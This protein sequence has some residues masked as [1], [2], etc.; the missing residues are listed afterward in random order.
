MK[1][2]QN[3]C[4]WRPTVS[5][6]RLGDAKGSDKSAAQYRKRRSHHRERYET[7]SWRE[8]LHVAPRPGFPL[9]G[10]RCRRREAGRT[11]G[12]R[13]SHDLESFSCLQSLGNFKGS[14][15]NTATVRRSRTLAVSQNTTSECAPIF[16]LL[17]QV[18]QKNPIVIAAR[19]SASHQPWHDAGPLRW[20]VVRNSG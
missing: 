19:D 7:G 16:R 15:T 13:L 2:G 14:S 1:T 12:H 5:R 20:S 4:Y 8:T 3:F 11:A 6:T 17:G 10:R 9:Q 18:S